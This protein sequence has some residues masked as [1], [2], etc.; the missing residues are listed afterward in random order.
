V[1]Q[2]NSR[3][4]VH[5]GSRDSTA[6]LTVSD[7]GP[8]IP[9]AERTRVFGRFVRL[10]SDRSRSGGGSGLGLAIVAEVV[11]AHGGTVAIGDRP[12]GGTTVIVTFPLNANR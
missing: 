2:A 10:D 3:V 6:V 9:P 1:R 11:A 8:G 12:G 4:D 7:D 5:V